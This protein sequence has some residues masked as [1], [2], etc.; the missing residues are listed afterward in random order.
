[1]RYVKLC[2]ILLSVSLL[3]NNTDSNDND[4]PINIESVTKKKD[5]K[6]PT[7]PIPEENPIVDIQKTTDSYETTFV[8]MI[9]VLI[10]LLIL[11]ILTIWMFKK[12]SRGRLRTLNYHKSIKILEKRP[13]S[14]KSMLYLIEIR[15]KRV[16]IS[17]SQCEMRN[18][19]T[20]EDK[21]IEKDL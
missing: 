15:G 9:L 18:I 21:S 1:M 20:L 14:P 16:L 10:G 11:V 4:A 19:T 5:H 7:P 3:A 6:E 13:L 8:K 17:E 2:I 12:F